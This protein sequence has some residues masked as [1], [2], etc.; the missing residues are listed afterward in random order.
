ML[1]VLLKRYSERGS[2][3]LDIFGGSGSTLIA[4]EELNR[5]CY[6]M[7]IDPIYVQ[8]IIDRWEKFTGIEPVK[9]GENK[10]L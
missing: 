2:L 6:M 8:V 10:Q 5:R 4:C 1:E 9:I 7:E 3:V